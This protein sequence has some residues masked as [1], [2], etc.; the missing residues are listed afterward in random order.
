MANLTDTVKKLLAACET[1][2]NGSPTL[3]GAGY[4]DCAGWNHVTWSLYLGIIDTTVDLK[5]Q[6][7]DDAATW[8]DIAGKALS[9]VPATGDGKPYV[10]EVPRGGS[11]GRKRYQ[12]AVCAVGNGSIGAALAIVAELSAF[13]SAVA[14]VASQDL[15][16]RV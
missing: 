11:T 6:E 12:K 5:I 9:Q 2:N 15:G 8:V 16:Q 1:K 14:D 13:S 3:L 10:I 7:S 4:V